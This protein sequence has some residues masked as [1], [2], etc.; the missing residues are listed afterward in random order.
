MM[1]VYAEFP[2]LTGKLLGIL[3]NVADLDYVDAAVEIDGYIE[4]I[5]RLH[6]LEKKYGIVDG[7][8][9]SLFMDYVRD[10]PLFS[11]STTDKYWLLHLLEDT[12]KVDHGIWWAVHRDMTFLPQSDFLLWHVGDGIWK[13]LT[14]GVSYCA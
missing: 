1:T 10:N 9:R 5:V 7:I 4:Q 8:V 13:M 6:V 2:E 12:L 11:T 14:T 3:K